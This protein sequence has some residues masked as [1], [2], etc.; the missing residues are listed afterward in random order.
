[1]TPSS[2]INKPIRSMYYMSALVGGTLHEGKRAY[3]E[4]LRTPHDNTSDDTEDCDRDTMGSGK[5]CQ[6]SVIPTLRDDHVST[7]SSFSSFVL[8]KLSEE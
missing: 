2:R 3:L 4:S 7:I 6:S 5:V 1:M 8:V